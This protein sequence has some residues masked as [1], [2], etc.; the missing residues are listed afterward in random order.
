MSVGLACLRLLH[1]LQGAGTQVTR[2]MDTQVLITALA[3][4]YGGKILFA[5]T[6]LGI[7]RCYKYPLTGEICPTLQCGM[8]IPA[9]Q[10]VLHCLSPKIDAS[11]RYIHLGLV[12]HRRMQSST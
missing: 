12:P 3:L 1:G 10:A 4:P 9:S 8:H 7:V 11:L 6:E 2:E 5:A